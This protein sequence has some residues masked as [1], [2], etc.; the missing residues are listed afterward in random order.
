MRTRSRMGYCSDRARAGHDL[1]VGV[2]RAIGA[3]ASSTAAERTAAA[4]R[5]TIRASVSASGKIDPAG[6]VNLNFG[7]PGTVQDVLVSE[8]DTVK[9]GDVIAQA[10]HRQSGISREAGRAGAGH[11]ETGLH[12]DDFAHGQR[13]RRRPGRHCQRFVEPEAARHAR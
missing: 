10:G 11:A 9:Q 1:V 7:T 3:T 8:G 6:K 13:C 4:K 2:Q 5:G 12:T